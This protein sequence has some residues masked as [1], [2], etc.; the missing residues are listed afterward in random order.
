MSVLH[1]VLLIKLQIDSPRALNYIVIKTLFITLTSG[2][3]TLRGHPKSMYMHVCNQDWIFLFTRTQLKRMHKHLFHALEQ[4]L[5]SLPHK[6]LLQD[7][8]RNTT[9]FLEKISKAANLV[10]DF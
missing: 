9:K 1:R 7:A 5:C 10:R 2:G 3:S 8:A 6:G 4:K